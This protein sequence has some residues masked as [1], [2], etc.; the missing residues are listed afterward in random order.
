MT[1]ENTQEEEVEVVSVMGIESPD[2][3]EIA[4]SFFEDVPR[5]EFPMEVPPTMDVI[6]DKLIEVQVN[7]VLCGYFGT[8]PD[9]PPDLFLA[10]RLLEMS[11]ELWLAAAHIATM[12][13]LPPELPD[14]GSVR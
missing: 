8:M 11:A 4:L 13:E 1:D 14:P 9:N 12:A 5:L 2:D 7:V 3:L 6:A 10:K